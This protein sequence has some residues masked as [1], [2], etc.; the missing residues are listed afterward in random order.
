[1]TA[2][3]S[4]AVKAVNRC[5]LVALGILCAGVLLLA[6]TPP[7]ARDALIHHLAIPKLWL[8]HGGFYETP[9]APFSYYPM[10][11][12]LIYLL[13]L[14]IG[15]D[16][17]PNIVH[18]CFAIGTSLLIYLYLKPKLGLT[19][20]LLGCLIWLSTPIVIHV[21]PTA[22]IDLGLTFFIT[23]AIYYMA[24]FME[25]EKPEKK[26][27]FLSAIFIGLALGSKYSALIA[28]PFFTCLSFFAASRY[29]GNWKAIKYTALYLVVSACLAAPW[30]I[31]NASL[32]GNPT[33]PFTTPLTYLLGKH[34]NVSEPL[35]VALFREDRAL[36]TSSML[37]RRVRYSEN[38]LEIFTVPLRIFWQGK[39]N[40]SRYFDGVLNPIYLLFLPF[41]W[42][43]SKEKKSL[44]FF[45]VFVWFFILMVFFLRGMRIRYVFPSLPPLV[46]VSV[47]GIRWLI[48]KTSTLARSLVMALI[49]GLLG[50]NFLYLWQRVDF[51]KPWQYLTASE[52]RDQFL[53]R[54][55]GSFAP[56]KWM[57]DH[58]PQN[59]RILF[60]MAGHRG[61]YCERAYLLAPDFGQRILEKMV[62]AENEEQLRRIFSGLNVTHLFTNHYLAFKFLKS[63]HSKGEIREL[64][65]RMKAISEIL[66][67]AGP[68]SVLKI[69]AD[70][71]R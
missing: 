54:L 53:S 29:G 52:S 62:R 26:F 31:K 14:I 44:L 48:D 20:A 70:Q 24:K 59:A 49:I 1:M 69:R 47:F 35:G 28:L 17:L 42:Y 5:L 50:M 18:L 60:L 7:Y 10:N 27:F 15:S 36:G 22:Y 71:P 68:Y 38:T 41:A 43:P 19:Y 4:P 8:K 6:L 13:C 51:I 2:I 40:D 3:D 61:Y 9:W 64:R 37:D 63:G 34:A 57:N 21:G 39:D 12:E 55:L 58:L 30:Y 66:Y 11:I 46:I 23:L 45:F 65:Q 32:T 56:I 67:E 16:I 33:Y 25:M